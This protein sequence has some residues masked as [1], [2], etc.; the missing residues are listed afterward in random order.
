MENLNSNPFPKEMTSQ[1]YCT[2]LGFDIKHFTKKVY[3][4]FQEFGPIENVGLN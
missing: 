2:T 3:Y 4:Y 1:Y